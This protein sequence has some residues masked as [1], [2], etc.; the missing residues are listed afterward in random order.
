[1]AGWMLPALSIALGSDGVLASAGDQSRCQARQA[2]SDLLSSSVA[3]IHGLL[4]ILTSTALTGVGPPCHPVYLIATALQGHP[5]GR[6]LQQHAA[7]GCFGHVVLPSRCP[8][9]R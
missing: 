7:D 9:A 4:S 6:R 3:F 1:M 8:R 5:G 2:N